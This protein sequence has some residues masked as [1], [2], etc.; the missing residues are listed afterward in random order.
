MNYDRYI[1]Q[2][3]AAVPPSGI[4]RFF[5]I[6]ATMKDAISLGVGEPDFVTPYHIRNA[7]INS[8]IDGGTQYTGNRGLPELCREI[9]EYLSERFHT[10]YDPKTEIM[11]TVGASEA[12]DIALRALVGP[13]DEVLVPQP[14]YVS[15]SPSVIFAGGT[16]VGVETTADTEFRLTPEALRAAITPRTK[17][18]LICSPANP[19]GSVLDQ[20]SL[21]TVAELAIRHNLLVLSDEI[22]ADMTYDRPMPPS[23]A[24]LPGMRERTIVLNGFSKYYAMTGWRIGYMLCPVKLMDPIMRLSFY[25]IA[26]PT[27]FIQS[28]RIAALEG[29]EGPSKAMLAEY[30]R[31]RD[32]M[33]EALNAMPGCRC[34]KPDGA[35]YIFVNIAGTGMDSDG[36]CRTMIDEA[37]VS[38]TPGHV[39]GTMGDG[40]VRVS[41]ANSM[42]NLQRA[43][44]LM[45]EVLEKRAA[46]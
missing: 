5:D 24:S 7:A 27:T 37:G 28:A 6:A 1:N 21:D 30:R 29:D 22:Y 44:I 38:M 23:I 32:F 36:F 14:S 19:C 39:F 42:E 8:I 17:A 26:C 40:F 31:R 43:V 25:N 41:Y 13:G 33:V 46:R 20:A 15:Y 35:F 45:R 12:I 34:R 18:I 2:A 10:D 9:S 4:R 3:I 11:V 16:P